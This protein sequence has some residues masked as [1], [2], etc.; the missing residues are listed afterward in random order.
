MW[1]EIPYAF[2]FSAPKT[3][4]A[5]Q[6]FKLVFLANGSPEANSNEIPWSQ[7][8]PHM[9]WIR[10]YAKPSTS[11]PQVS[12][13]TAKRNKLQEE[14]L[15]RA[16]QRE[17][18]RKQLQAAQAAQDEAEQAL[19]DLL[20]IDPEILQGEDVSVAESEIDQ[21]LADETVDNQIQPAEAGTMAQVEDFD[22]ENG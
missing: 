15:Q 4:L 9:S 10:G 17:K 8:W 18:H 12:P 1:T 6:N 21:L 20:E 22:I 16:E 14:R 3:D 7:A 5:S 11:E 2:E 13:R 19:K